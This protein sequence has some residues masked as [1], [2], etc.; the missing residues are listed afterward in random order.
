MKK[1]IFAVFAA[2]LLALSVLLP[3]YAQNAM[4]DSD[5]S[6]E[7]LLPRLV[8]N[9][10]LLSPEEESTLLTQLDEAS[11][12]RNYDVVIV[13][14]K[15]LNG[16]SAEAFADDFYDY[17]GYGMGD[18][19]DGVMLL[20]S[21]EEREYH[22]TTSGAVIDAINDSRIE[23]IGEEIT[24]YLSSGEYFE[25]FETFA[26]ICGRSKIQPLHI[27]I[28]IAIGCIA[29][30]I[31]VGTMKAKLKTVRRQ[32]AANDYVRENSLNITH[33]SDIYLYTHVKRHAKPKNNGSS[34]SS[35]HVSSSGATHGGGGGKF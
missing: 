32:P 17:N 11:E 28:S 31:V 6:A 9:A 30:F 10:D 18:S 29:A 1:G 8:D 23:K 35:T 20:V 16:K 25:A 7:Y 33:S 34:G 14:V 3:V 22:I 19:K 24:P 15:S 27:I 5:L 13:T 2:I 4:A 12:R 26:S 21:M